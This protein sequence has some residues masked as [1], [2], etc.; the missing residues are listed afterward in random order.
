MCPY[1]NKKKVPVYMPVPG[2]FD[3]SGLV[4]QFD[5][6]YC[7]PSNLVPLSQDC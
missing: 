3:Y 5:I 2:C 6:S 4:I 1:N 7:D